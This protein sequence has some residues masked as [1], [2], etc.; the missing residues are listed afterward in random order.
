MTML[1]SLVNILCIKIF[2]LIK[3]YVDKKICEIKK[4]YVRL[5]NHLN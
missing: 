3:E 4:E 1:H 2:D 5:K